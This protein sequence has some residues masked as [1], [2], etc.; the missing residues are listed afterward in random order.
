MVVTIL[1]PVGFG[2]KSR[3]P[4]SWTEVCIWIPWLHLI[5]DGW[6]SITVSGDQSNLPHLV[7]NAQPMGQEVTDRQQQGQNQNGLE[8][9]PKKCPN[10]YGYTKGTVCFNRLL[11]TPIENKVSCN[12][13]LQI[14]L[15][16]CGLSQ[17]Q[18]W[19]GL[20]FS[21]GSSDIAC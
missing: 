6:N 3:M 18:V 14:C 16:C 2:L 17:G 19:V 21:I 15:K 5:K 7:D 10:Y 13:Y 1:H 12:D 9:F 4:S 20:V 11:S 8:P